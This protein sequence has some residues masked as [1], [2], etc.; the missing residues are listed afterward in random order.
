MS[1]CG[2]LPTPTAAQYRDAP[3]GERANGTGGRLILL[4]RSDGLG[5]F[6]AFVDDVKAAYKKDPSASIYSIEQVLTEEDRN[7]GIWSRQFGVLR[8]DVLEVLA[9]F[10]DRSS[11]SASAATAKVV[12]AAKVAPTQ[13]KLPTPAVAPALPAAAKSKLPIPLIAGAG[14]LLLAVLVL[15]K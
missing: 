8:A 2:A 5:V 10:P 7:R 15:R 9:K 4:P 12:P 11:A 1:Y 3:T 13:Y 14:V 6:W